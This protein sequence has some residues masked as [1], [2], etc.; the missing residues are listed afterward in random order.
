MSEEPIYAD[1][2]RSSSSLIFSFDF[3]RKE[4]Y[5]PGPG[6]LLSLGF[7]VDAFGV[8]EINIWLLIFPYKI[9]SLVAS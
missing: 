9:C 4:K 1:N 7:D 8:L 5:D 6:F 2:G 3:V